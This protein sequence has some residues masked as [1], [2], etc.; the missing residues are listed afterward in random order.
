M[1]CLKSTKHYFILL[2]LN[3]IIIVFS[4]SAMSDESNWKGQ[5]LSAKEVL[6]KWG[7]QKFDAKKF[8]SG[9]EIDRSKMAYS[10]L[11]DQS[12]I[13]QSGSKIYEDLG[14]YSGFFFSD[15]IPAYLIQFANKPGDIE[16]QIVFV[17]DKNR[18]VSEVIVQEVG[19]ERKTEQYQQ[20]RKDLK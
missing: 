10:L 1:N 18:K 4:T 15:N 17:M 20:Y 2:L 5:T 12:Y 13:G 7:S 16:W 6:A 19:S 14:S 9:N 8:K 11:N 3:M